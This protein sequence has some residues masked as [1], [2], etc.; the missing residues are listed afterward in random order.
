MH[1]LT[2]HNAT[3]GRVYLDTTQP[4]DELGGEDVEKEEWS[5][6]KGVFG[7]LSSYGFIYR[8]IVK[9]SQQSS[10]RVILC[11]CKHS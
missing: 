10:R 1:E 9:V 8:A 11:C 6:N 7:N 4:E 5:A 2:S 3:H